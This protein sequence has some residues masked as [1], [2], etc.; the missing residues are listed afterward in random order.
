MFDHHIGENHGLALCVVCSL[1]T[2]VRTETNAAAAP[3][4]RALTELG[5][6]QPCHKDTMRFRL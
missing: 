5:A 3:Y 4:V 2:K 1:T 6:V